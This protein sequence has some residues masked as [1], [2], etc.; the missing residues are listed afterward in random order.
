[1]QTDQSQLALI[2]VFPKRKVNQKPDDTWRVVIDEQ[3]YRS[4]C[5]CTER[6]TSREK[7]W[8]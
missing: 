4:S 7:L 6:N 3:P 8:L 1:M 2:K 5:P